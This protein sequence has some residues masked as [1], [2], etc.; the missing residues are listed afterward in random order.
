MSDKVKKG[1]DEEEPKVQEP[2]WICA[3][4]LDDTEDISIGDDYGSREDAIAGAVE[5]LGNVG[6]GESFQT[7]RVVSSFASPDSPFDAA[8]I[9]ERTVDDMH[10]VWASGLCEMWEGKANAASD[11]LRRRLDE[12]WGRWI[13]K[14]KLRVA[15]LSIEDIETHE[16]PKSAD[17]DE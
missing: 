12:L 8:D 1:D 15:V 7:G 2:Y 11:D 5:E 14:H 16:M 3:R 4:S 9:I 13:E 17:D 10:D 6:V